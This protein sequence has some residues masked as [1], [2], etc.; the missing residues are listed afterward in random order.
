[1]LV[2]RDALLKQRRFRQIKTEI[3]DL[4]IV[5]LN[6]RE[7]DEVLRG[8][9]AA[10]REGEVPE[11]LQFRIVRWC[12]VDENREPLFTAEDD[13]GIGN[14]SGSLI[15]KIVLAVLDLSG[16][17]EEGQEELGKNSESDPSDGAGSGSQKPLAAVSPKHRSA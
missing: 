10:G 8:I 9:T 5:E 2:G 3:G 7:R 12:V 14:M 15:E 13:E 4:G 17:T 6:G 16:I 11:G 1:M